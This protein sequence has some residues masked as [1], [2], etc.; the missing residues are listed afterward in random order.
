MRRFLSLLKKPEII[1]WL[2]VL[3]ALAGSVAVLGIVYLHPEKLQLIR[4]TS[5]WYAWLSGSVATGIALVVIGIFLFFGART[6]G[7]RSFNKERKNAQGDDVKRVLKEDVTPVSAAVST[8]QQIR[9]HLRR[10]Y[11]LFWRHK[12][13]LLLITGDE[14]AIEQL[15]P[16]LQESQWLEGNRTVLIYGGSLAAEPDREKYTALR[17]LRRGRP[18][19]GIV[20]VL[21]ESLNLTPQISDNDLRGLEKIS[22]LLRYSAPVWLWQLCGSRWSQAKRTEQTVGASFPL[23]AT[24]GDITRQLE[25]MLPALRTQGV[26]QVAE[27][28]S[29]DFLLRLGQH[30][31]EGGIARWT[32]Q[33]APW[34]SVSQQRVP[35]R[36]LMFS[37]PE[38]TSADI[39]TLT[40]SA[41]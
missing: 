13:R 40:A 34:L 15:I 10:R 28:N 12:T 24:A 35:L 2:V 39:A 4:E 18:L 8:C 1:F 30:L 26:S 19:D 25:L 16:G 3:I 17:K 23:R 38:N 20:R 9:S 31:K 27:N 33:L 21:P 11:N 22:E 37:L 5:S 29:H 7:K 32:Q 36:G 6:E 41:E 14:A